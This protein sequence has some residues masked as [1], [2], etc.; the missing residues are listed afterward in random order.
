MESSVNIVSTWFY[1]S[2]IGQDFD[3]PGM[4]PKS[5]DNFFQLSYFKCVINFFASTFNQV[6][7]SPNP[8]DY[9]LQFYYNQLPEFLSEI[10]FFEI[11]NNLNVELIQFKPKPLPD[12]ISDKKLQFGSQFYEF[13]VIEEVLR[14]NKSGDTIALLDNDCLFI[15]DISRIFR[16][17]TESNCCETVIVHGCTNPSE[18]IQGNTVESLHVLSDLIT[19]G[20]P[21]RPYVHRG[22][23]YLF[24]NYD[25][26]TEFYEK[27]IYTYKFNNN[28]ANSGELFFTTEEQIF[29]HCYRFMPVVN[30]SGF[31]K[32]SWTDPKTFCNSDRSDLKFSIL[33][34]PADKQRGLR[35]LFDEIYESF[36]L[37]STG[38]FLNSIGLI[39]SKENLIKTFPSF[40]F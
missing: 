13:D 34:L 12:F 26:L 31:L 23:E 17:A 28:L 14:N 18:V 38:D 24:M 16:D 10:K 19:S 40:S 30:D 21:F 32:R 1:S 15:N 7:N 5:S 11:M 20:E 2:S 22:G 33:H 8:N 27:I 37:H 3:Y 36:N 4:G 9:R 29:S 6:R 39:Y 35:S 25:L